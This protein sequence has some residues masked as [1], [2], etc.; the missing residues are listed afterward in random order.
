MILAML[1]LSLP[2]G[3]AVDLVSPNLG[4]SDANRD[5]SEGLCMPV[6]VVDG[7]S[8]FTCGGGSDDHAAVVLDVPSPLI[9]D[10]NRIHPPH[11]LRSSSLKPVRI[12]E[13]N[14]AF[15]VPQA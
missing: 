12:S 1:S 3:L 13:L 8:L 2:A 14:S 9:N 15:P 10:S 7:D 5:A 6:T 11:S 4:T